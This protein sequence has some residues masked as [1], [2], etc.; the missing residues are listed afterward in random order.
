LSN[1]STIKAEVPY[2]MS[3]DPPAPFMDPINPMRPI[4]SRPPGS[5]IPDVVLVKDETVPPVQSN[6]RKIIEIK[7][8]GDPEDRAQTAI[9][10]RIG[11]PG[12]PVETWT[13]KTCECGEEEPDRAP[14]RARVPA[15]TP[16]EEA[17]I[18]VLTIL[19]LAGDDLLVP[20]GGEADD[21]AILPLLARLR[22]I[23]AL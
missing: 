17:L 18:L 7:F 9:F 23:L 12:V 13:P 22:Q 3:L 1:Q 20:V 5:R 21:A 10:K 6:I 16:R 11:G 4:H 19:V 2:D 14:A 8:D 15:L